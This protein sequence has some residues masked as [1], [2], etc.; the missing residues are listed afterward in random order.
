MKRSWKEDVCSI[1]NESNLAKE[2]EVACGE[3]TEGGSFVRIRVKSRWALRHGT[4]RNLGA[5][6]RSVLAHLH[7]LALEPELERLNRH[8]CVKQ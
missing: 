2:T 5:S 8:L 4:T 7:T 1:S 6:A 3:E